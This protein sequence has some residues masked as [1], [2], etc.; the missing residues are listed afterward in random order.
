MAT[1]KVHSVMKMSFREEGKEMQNSEHISAVPTTGTRLYVF[2]DSIR[3][4]NYS[5][6]KQ[7]FIAA[8]PCLINTEKEREEKE[9]SC[10]CYFNI[11]V[12]ICFERE[13]R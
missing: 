6:E 2:Q 11:K 7:F 8:D 3:R 13:C 5:C 4:Q 9:F 10:S 1:T 12:S